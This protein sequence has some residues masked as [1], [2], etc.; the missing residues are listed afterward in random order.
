VETRVSEVGPVVPLGVR[1]QIRK[2]VLWFRNLGV[3]PGDAMVCAYPRSGST[4]LR[5]LLYEALTSQPASFEL[6]NR[7]IPDPD[8][9]R[10]APRLLPSGGRLLKSHDRYLPSG[11]K[12]VYMVRDVRDVVLSEYRYHVREGTFEGDFAAFLQPFLEGK[13]SYF[14]SWSDHVRFW[15][16]DGSVPPEDLFLLRFESLREGTVDVLDRTLRFLG[17]EV[18]SASLENAVRNNAIE[19]MRRKE[20]EA[21]PRAIRTSDPRLRFVGRGLVGGWRQE[22]SDAQ[23]RMIESYAGD[24]LARLG[25][26][27]EKEAGRGLSGP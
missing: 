10:R 14:G 2:P 19:R 15:A 22:L 25:Y 1:K 20:E 6:V 12:V 26:A 27:I 8:G 17:A 4:W 5:F 16:L 18:D 23:R 7:G 11:A 9:Y 21:P 24:A 13:I 3:G